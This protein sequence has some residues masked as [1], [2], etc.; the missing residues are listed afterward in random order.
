MSL[1]DRKWKKVRG[2]NA[3]RNGFQ[4]KERW[5]TRTRCLF[6]ALLLDCKYRNMHADSVG[7]HIYMGRIFPSKT[8]MS[9]N[10]RSKQP[11]KASQRY[12]SPVF[13]SMAKNSRLQRIWNSWFECD[14]FGFECGRQMANACQLIL[15]HSRMG[16]PSNVRIDVECT[17]FCV[18]VN[19]SSSRYNQINVINELL[20]MAQL[21]SHDMIY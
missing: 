8:T 18:G 2:G 19:S 7:T 14:W 6:I 17:L 4:N 1:Q 13:N 15:S 5:L 21:Q 20:S 12:S 9:Y 16:E 3:T 11:L 10:K